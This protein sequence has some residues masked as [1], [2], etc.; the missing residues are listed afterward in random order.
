MLIKFVSM[1]TEHVEQW[2]Q[3]TENKFVADVWFIEGYELRERIYEKIRGNGYDY[4]YIILFDNVPIGYICCCDLYAYKNIHPKP[5]GNFSNEVEGTYCFDLFIGE[6]KYL[7]QGYGTEIV[8]EF[9]D[10]LFVTF[11]VTKML[12]DPAKDNLRAIRCYEKAGFTFV[13]ESFDGVTNCYI[14]ER[15]KN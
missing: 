10:Y 7:D 6:E 14:M 9:V 12:I 2:Y 5:K 15:L 1:T 11:N 3:W 13:K 4:P 8:K